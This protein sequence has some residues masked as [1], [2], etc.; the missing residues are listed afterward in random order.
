VNLRKLM[1]GREA[2]LRKLISMRAALAHQAYFGGH[3]I[4]GESFL[5]WRILLIAIVGEELDEEERAVFK[6]LTAREREPGKPIEEFWA[7]VG[8]RGGKTQ[9]MSV[10]SAYLAAC[11]D[12][13]HVLGP[14]ERGKLPLLAASTEQAKQAFGFVKGIFEGSPALSALV[15]SVTQDAVSLKTRIDIVI[16]PAS[17]RTIRGIS[18]VAAVCDEMCSW[19]ATEESANPAKEVL[20]ALRPALGTT[21][22]LLAVISTPR[23]RL[24]P[25]YDTFKR[26][27]GANGHRSI[28]VARAPTL[29]MNATYPRWK[30]DREYEED[31]ENARAEYDVEWRAD[32]SSLVPVEL[33]EGAV[34]VG[35][36]VRP[37]RAGVSYRSFVDAASGTGQDNFAVGIAHK[38]DR[39]IILDLAHEVKPPFSPESAISEISEIMKGYNILSCTGD[40]WAKNFVSEGFSRNGVHYTYSDDDKSGIYLNALPLFTSGRVRLVDN[41]RLVTQ[42]TTLERRVS[43]GG[44]DAVDHGRNAHDD[45]CNAAAGALVLAATDQG[46]SVSPEFLEA[47]RAG[48][49]ARRFRQAYQ[50]HWAGF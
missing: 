32:V 7:I 40:K 48:F 46:I 34:D 26:H 23:A 8:R 1:L 24:G 27:Y 2:N 14:G 41:S 37:P 33:I 35:V 5:K 6:E 9:A 10:L 20:R 39:Q 30:I 36:T 25:L 4:A 15:E 38:E 22:G 11:V 3:P 13:C 17:W 49:S 28:L 12:Y 50:Q 43:P 47:T 19:M 45:L 42:F 44:K 21:S 18:A 16:R 31:P 29:A